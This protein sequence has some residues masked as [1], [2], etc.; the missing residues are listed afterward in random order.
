MKI[1]YLIGSKLE[2]LYKLIRLFFLLQKHRMERRRLNRRIEDLEKHLKS[3]E[4]M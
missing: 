2:W 3:L 1:P 4:K